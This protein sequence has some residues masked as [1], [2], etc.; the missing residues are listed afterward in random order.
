MKPG[1]DNQC[2]GL[3]FVPSGD[4]G[5]WVRRYKTK[6]GKMKQYTFARYPETDVDAAR[7]Y[8]ESVRG[9]DNPLLLTTGEPS[10][11]QLCD[12]YIDE[13]IKHNRSND[14]LISVRSA[15][16][17]NLKPIASVPLDQVNA[18]ML[19]ELILTVK[20]R[21]P[22]MAMLM[23]SEL[24]QAWSYGLAIGMTNISC[25]ITT[26]TG[27]RFRRNKRDRILSD[28]EVPQVLNNL[29]LYSF[30]LQDVIRI[31]LYTGL[32]SGEVVR[33]HSDWFVDD[34]GVLWLTIP[35]EHMKNGMAH[36]VPFFGAALDA[37]MHRTV[38]GPGYLFPQKRNPQKHI[39]QVALSREIYRVD[40]PVKDWR[41]HDLRR[42]T[43][44]NLQRI[45][46]P[47]EVSETILA[48]KL[49]GVSAVYARFQYNDEKIKWLTKL[50]EYYDRIR[51]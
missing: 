7:E 30:A 45:G 11:D 5:R 43:R 2:P 15:L 19:H 9:Q 34:G 20:K 16:K 29:H 44:T 10:I 8:V 50:A 42:T 28:T 36:R 23:R 1:A 31:C 47:F 27:G 14:V 35:K 18:A 12:K 13:Y 4:G 17:R 32:R 49:P 46:C 38:G 40:S 39:T 33:L 24:K 6:T 22:S 48:H 41:L 21:A 51:Q 3:R 25:P 26:L 37:W